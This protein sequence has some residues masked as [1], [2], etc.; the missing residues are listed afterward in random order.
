MVSAIGNELLLGM[1][2]LAGHKLVIEVTPGG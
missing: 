2:L 1:H